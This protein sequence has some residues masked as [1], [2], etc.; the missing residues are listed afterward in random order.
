MDFFFALE[1]CG[2]IFKPWKVQFAAGENSWAHFW[3]LTRRF[4]S[5]WSR[6]NEVYCEFCPE[7]AATLLVS[8]SLHLNIS[9]RLLRHYLLWNAVCWNVMCT[10]NWLD[11]TR[12]A[13]KRRHVVTAVTHIWKHTTPMHVTHSLS[14]IHLLFTWNHV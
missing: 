12:E 11:L 8:S 13:N 9:F 7:K 14:L 2:Y 6:L 5:V 4:E 3:C 1:S 10:Q